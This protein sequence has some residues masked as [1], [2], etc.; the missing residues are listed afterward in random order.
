MST[1]LLCLLA[2]LW[3]LVI[4]HHLVYPII[5][6]AVLKHQSSQKEKTCDPVDKTRTHPER[7]LSICILVPAFNEADIIADKIR[8]IAS[9]DYPT[10]Q[11]KLIIACDGC[12]DDTA[13]IARDAAL[14]VENKTI[15]IEIIEF[16]NNRGKIAILNQLIP[17][18][19]S[20]IVALSDASA[21]ISIDGLQIANEL[22]QDPSIGVVAATYKLLN[23]GSQGEQKYW[24]YQIDV[25]K[26]EAAI[27]S[28]IGVHGALYF[29]RQTLFTPLS[30]EVINDDFILPMKIIE[31]G[32]R[33]VYRC[34]LVALEL[35]QASLDMDQKRRIR[36]AAGNLQQLIYL[37]GLLR[38]KHSGTAF[39]FFSG[40]ALRALMPLVLLI[41][42]LACLYLAID[43]DL[44]QMIASAQ[45]IG[46]VVAR[47]S[48]RLSDK[49][50]KNIKTTKLLKPML[51]ICYLVNGYISGLI[52]TL[53]Y[54]FGL[55]RG[56]W[57]SVPKEDRTL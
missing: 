31:Q 41:Q 30:P 22:F 27:G 6:L 39:S 34:D 44:F 16:A 43:S 20:D 4:Y 46:I 48:L 52:G 45:V 26:G 9:L 50:N 24:D 38:P 29:F 7:E 3:C 47:L 12:S 54:L 14:E 13:S 57:K 36:I 37:P 21:L 1:E 15:T 35:E 2:L 8:N 17:T 19:E 32:Y 10:Q 11:L 25:K 56:C 42:L 53:R 28:P 49:I 33:G 40:K 55:E 23:P 51:L 5:L 18:I